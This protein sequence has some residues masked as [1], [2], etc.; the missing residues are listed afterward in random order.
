MH[1]GVKNDSITSFSKKNIPSAQLI[2]TA[3]PYLNWLPNCQF[4]NQGGALI[5]QR[6]RRGWGTGGFFKK[7]SA[8]LS[9][10]ATYRMS[11]ISAGSISLDSTFKFR[12]L[13][14]Y[15]PPPPDQQTGKLVGAILV[16]RQPG[17]SDL[18]E[19][20][21]SNSSEPMCF[22][23]DSAIHNLFEPTKSNLSERMCS[24]SDQWKHYCRNLLEML[25]S[26]WSKAMCSNQSTLSHFVKTG[27]FQSVRNHL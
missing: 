8:P 1:N 22:Q 15:V 25:S 11:L 7:P 5:L 14:Q 27:V 3:R 12:V 16:D 2:F 10:M 21:C 4:Q 6:A 19:P 24:L 26:N 17:P 9:L 23:S 13:I 18:P 20:M